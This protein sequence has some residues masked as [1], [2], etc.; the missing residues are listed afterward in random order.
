[1]QISWG[2]HPGVATEGV[3]SGH[4]A[5]VGDGVPEFGG[6]VGMPGGR[7]ASDARSC[8]HALERAAE[9]F[10]VERDGVHQGK[11]RDSYRASVCRTAKELCRPAFL[12]TRLLGLNGRQKRGCRAPVYP[13]PGTGRQTP[14]TTGTGGAL[15]AASF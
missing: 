4:P 15:S 9:V 12:G 2:I 6:A 14:R 5:G 8:A 11:E 13:E 3:V 7:G 1:M 10:G